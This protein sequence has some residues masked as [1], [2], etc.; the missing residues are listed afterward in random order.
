MPPAGWRQPPLL[1][2]GLRHARPWRDRPVEFELAG[3]IA[4]RY[5][6]EAVSGNIAWRHARD[7]DEL[8][9]TSPLG[10]GVARIVRAGQRRHAHHAGRRSSPRRGRRIA[11]RAGARLPP[12]ARRAGRLGARPRRSP[13]SPAHAEHG[14]RRQACEAASSPAGTSSTRSTPGAA[15]AAS[16]MRL[17]YPGIELRLAISRVEMS[18]AL[19]SRARKAQPVPARPR[20][21]RRRLPRAAD[22]VP[23]DRPLRPGRHRAARR[24][25]DRASQGIVRGG[26]PLRARG[27]PAAGAHSA[28]P[29]GCDI[30]LEK[31]LPIGGGLG[32]GCSDAATVLLV[33]NRLW[34]SWACEAEEL[35]QLGAAAGRRRAVLRVRPQR[36]RRGRRRAPAARSICRPPGTS[37]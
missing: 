22:R 8:L 36:A 28:C 11:H 26:Q 19:V 27:A 14:A 17:T 16:R 3:R 18:P 2:C 37:F 5:R 25:R 9:I 34:Q 15:V 30:A 13:G 12:A 10:Q 35:M 32:G 20:P 24:R 6:N 23:P 29:Q 4:V 7:G 21:P 1:L 33:L 31:S